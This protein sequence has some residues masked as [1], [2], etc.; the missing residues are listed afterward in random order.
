[1][2]KRSGS[3]GCFHMGGSGRKDGEEKAAGR[4]EATLEMG[5]G[6]GSILRR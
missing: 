4:A 3:G 1:L 5:D 6:A 2:G